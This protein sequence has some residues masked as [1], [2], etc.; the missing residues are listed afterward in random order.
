MALPSFRKQLSW[1]S[2]HS[3]LPQNGFSIF[4]TLFYSL[5]LTSSQRKSFR[6]H[7]LATVAWPL[8]FHLCSCYA[9]QRSNRVIN[10]M[11]IQGNAA[12]LQWKHYSSQASCGCSCPDRRH[13]YAAKTIPALL[14]DKSCLLLPELC[15]HQ[16]Y[17]WQNYINYSLWSFYAPIRPSPTQQNSVV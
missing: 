15:P 2:V 6:L 10:A 7:S 14:N 4:Y 17:C 8:P 11:S 1:T 3:G 16:E 5:A 13:F 9:M 12:T